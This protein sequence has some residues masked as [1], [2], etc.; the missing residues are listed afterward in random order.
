LL[1]RAGSEEKIA[2]GAAQ[3]VRDAMPGDQR[4]TE[5]F[6]MAPLEPAPI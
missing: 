2:E 3:Q 6:D 4:R 1:S 5:L